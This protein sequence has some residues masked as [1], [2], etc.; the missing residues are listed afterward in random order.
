MQTGAKGTLKVGFYWWSIKKERR[1][2]KAFCREPQKL[3]EEINMVGRSQC[4]LPWSSEG[5]GIR[6]SWVTPESLRDRTIRRVPGGWQYFG[7]LIWDFSLGGGGF[8]FKYKYPNILIRKRKTS[9]RR[10]SL[11]GAPHVEMLN[12]EVRINGRESQVNSFQGPELVW[13][14]VRWWE[15]RQGQLVT[16]VQ[17]VEAKYVR[18]PP[19]PRAHLLKLMRFTWGG[20][21]TFIFKLPFIA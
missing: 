16:G 7:I 19:F 2:L 5:T 11:R 17:R 21:V 3:T 15:R 13:C 4:C 8:F 6:E 10:C 12:P 20:E 9:T 14:I 18:L 1:N